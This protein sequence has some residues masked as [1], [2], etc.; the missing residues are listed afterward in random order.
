[1]STEPDIAQALREIGIVAELSGQ[2]SNAVQNGEKEKA[3]QLLQSVRSGFLTE[4]HVSQDRLYRLDY[5][6]RSLK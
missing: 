5:I 2:I 6:I 1:M 4:L 3:L